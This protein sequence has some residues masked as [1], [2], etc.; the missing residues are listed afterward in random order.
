M[1]GEG[2]G[3]SRGMETI[4]VTIL[5][6]TPARTRRPK[7]FTY[8]V[9]KRE[10]ATLSEFRMARPR[11]FETV[12]DQVTACFK[13]TV[14]VAGSMGGTS[15]EVE[16]FEVVTPFGRGVLF[17]GK[18]YS[19]LDCWVPS[20]GGQALAAGCFRKY[21]KYRGNCVAYLLAMG[22]NVDSKKKVDHCCIARLYAGAQGKSY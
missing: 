1:I 19:E 10:P 18:D 3:P 6:G 5:S 12:G 22:F 20:N 9:T 16:Y 2:L 17:L 11:W 15:H 21:G 4:T 13:V 8:T 14:T 7:P